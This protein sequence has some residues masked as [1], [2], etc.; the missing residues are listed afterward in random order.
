MPIM[1]RSCTLCRMPF[2]NLWSVG[3][4]CQ[5]CVMPGATDM[6]LLNK[7]LHGGESHEKNPRECGRSATLCVKKLEQPHMT[8]IK[9]K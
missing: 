9:I 1:H 4:C 3:R 2:L 6:T 7:V 8:T 5:E